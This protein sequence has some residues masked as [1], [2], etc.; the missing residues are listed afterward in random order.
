MD[1]HVKFKHLIEV[2]GFDTSGLH[3][4][5]FAMTAHAMKGDRE[6]CLEA[7]MDGY[8]TKPIRISDIEKS[9][10]TVS[11]ASSISVPSHSSPAT[12]KSQTCWDRTQAL[13]RLGGDENLLRELCQIFVQESPKLLEK[14]GQAIAAQDAEAAMRAA[15]SIKGDVSYLAAEGA[16]QAARALEEMGH[17]HD[18]S[19]ATEMFALLEQELGQLHRSMSVPA[20]AAQ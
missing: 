8:V 19:G 4:P 20:G 17:S 18:L 6:R 11:P 2:E 1:F 16:L 5:I 10:A 7:G 12:T 3:L 9:L 13:D 15:H 14:L